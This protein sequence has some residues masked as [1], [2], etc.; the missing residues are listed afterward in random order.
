MSGFN[1]DLGTSFAGIKRT[2]DIRD[3]GSMTV[4]LEQD[5]GTFLDA[6]HD[7]RETNAGYNMGR[8]MKRVACIPAVLRIH[9]MN[10]EGWDPLDPDC[11]DRLCR[12]LNDP[13]YAK[14]RT[15]YGVLGLSN[16]EM[17]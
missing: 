8:D 17:R 11:V 12:L 4:K 3:D 10:T 1:F 13:D 9:L 2:A 6:C 7:M 14:I 16:G 5:L 15:A